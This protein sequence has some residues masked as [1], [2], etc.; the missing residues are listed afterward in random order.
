MPV[1]ERLVSRLEVKDHP[2]LELS[3][4]SL[5]NAPP[6]EWE[7]PYHQPWSWNGTTSRVRGHPGYAILRIEGKDQRVHR[8]LYEL[9]VG[10]I[11]DLHY[12]RG[13]YLDVN[14]THW[15]LAHPPRLV[16][17]ADFDDPD[18]APIATHSQLTDT[19]TPQEIISLANAVEEEYTLRPF[20]SYREFLDR[21]DLMIEG[22]PE[23][24]I[25]Q[26]ITK[27]GLAARLLEDTC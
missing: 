20:T 26:I 9:L 12:L 4:P 21:F 7:K 22:L 5:V 1:W 11:P 15:K 2:G 24:Q 19:V 8:L 17:A 27:A 18:L 25:R 6:H 13:S 14:P 3:I 16:T 23:S 10:P